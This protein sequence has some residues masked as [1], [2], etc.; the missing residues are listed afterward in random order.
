MNVDFGTET[1]RASRVWYDRASGILYTETDG[2]V[3]G[4]DFQRIPD[5]DFES[6]SP[7]IRFELACEGT[8]VV[9]RHQDG[10]ETWFPIDMW[11]PKGF[12]PPSPKSTP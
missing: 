4:I 10:V 9:C 7:V 5:H 2:L 11:L 8:V 3:Q 1:I 12:T 6:A